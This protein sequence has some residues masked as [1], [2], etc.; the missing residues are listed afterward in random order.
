MENPIKEMNLNTKGYNDLAEKTGIRPNTLRQIARMSP[1]NC[2]NVRLHTMVKLAEH[3]INL[4]NYYL[5]K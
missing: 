3:G 5:S 1:D 2:K 4:T